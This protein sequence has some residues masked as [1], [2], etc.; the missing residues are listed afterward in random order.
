VRDD[1]KRK[2]G[3]K[4]HKNGVNGPGKRGMEGKK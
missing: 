3:S 4:T 2:F 1:E